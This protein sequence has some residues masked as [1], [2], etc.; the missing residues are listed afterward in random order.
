MR[1]AAIASR[2]CNA[3]CRRIVSKAASNSKPMSNPARRC[4]SRCGGS[5]RICR[6]SSPGAMAACSVTRWCSNTNGARTARCPSACSRRNARRT[7]CSNSGADAWNRR[8]CRHRCGAFA[9]WRTS[10]RR[11]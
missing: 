1:C 3:T 8:D 7:C 10:C 2:R 11:S 4:C 6:P 9:W 5:R